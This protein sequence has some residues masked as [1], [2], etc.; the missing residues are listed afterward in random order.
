[1]RQGSNDACRLDLAE[2]EKGVQV[3]HGHGHDTP[4]C[5]IGGADMRTVWVAHTAG[6]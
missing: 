6:G 2:G 3:Q 4:P 1:M 5:G